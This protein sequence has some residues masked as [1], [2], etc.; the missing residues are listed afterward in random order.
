MNNITFL[1]LVVCGALERQERSHAE[2]L[3]DAEREQLGNWKI[4]GEVTKLMLFARN[5]EN[6]CFL[7]GE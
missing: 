7:L 4:N 6:V 3:W 5:V 1:S 2:G